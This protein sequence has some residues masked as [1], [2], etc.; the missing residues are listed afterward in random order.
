[1]ES[2]S[3]LKVLEREAHELTR[4]YALRCLGYNI[5]NLYLKPGQFVSE[6]SICEQLGISRTPVREAFTK[7][8]SEKLVVI[9]PQIG[10]CVA[11]ISAEY[12]QEARFTRWLLERAVVEKVCSMRKE[13]DLCWLEEN[14]ASQHDILNSRDSERFL[15]LDNQFHQKLFAIAKMSL[16]MSLIHGLLVHFDRVR[17]LYLKDLDWNR[18]IRE[19]E[20][21]FLAIKEQNG[22]GAADT[23]DLHLS[24]VL[25]DMNI[26]SK[27]Y[28]QYFMA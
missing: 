22:E 25:E 11:P 7:L 18:T 1:M 21:I 3:A 24:R 5:C 14:L 6:Q 10:T 26:L 2:N 19:H 15:E 23:M 20:T 28:P 12:V 27:R 13:E 8:A 17:L 9:Y 4:D 16:T